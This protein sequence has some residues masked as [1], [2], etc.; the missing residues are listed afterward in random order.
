MVSSEIKG[1]VGILRVKSFLIPQVTKAAID[2]AK[3]KLS[4]AKVII[5]DVR[6]NG[7]GAGSSISYLIEDIIGADKAIS[8]DRT[9]EG[10]QIKE[11]YIFHGYFDDA[12]NAEGAAE[13]EFS[14]KHPYVEWRTRLKAKKDPR[15]HFILV[16]DKCGSA[17]DLFAAAA[18]DYDIKILGVRTV[19]A[20]FGGDAFRLKWQG[21]ALIVPTLQVVTA[22]GRII[23]GVGV[24]PDILIPECKTNESKCLEK[25]LK[26]AA[27]AS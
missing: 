18:Q 17:C 12:I 14:E 16:D 19:G 3:A 2:Q 15:S 26:I 7:G 10:L 4:Q 11:P 22:K 23:E 24:K 9:R 20:L 25:A 27:K 13:I 21:Y 8:R 1:E 5:V 6:G